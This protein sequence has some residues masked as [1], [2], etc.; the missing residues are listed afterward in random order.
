MTIEKEVKIDSGK[1]FTKYL[2]E[3]GVTIYYN[4]NGNTHKA[5]VSIPDLITNLDGRVS[6]TTQIIKTQDYQFTLIGREI[7]ITTL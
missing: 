5:F 4:K 2:A 7:G 6:L 1:C 3:D